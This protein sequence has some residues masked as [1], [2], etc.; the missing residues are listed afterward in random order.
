MLSDLKTEERLV[1]RGLRAEG[2]SVKEVAAL[3]GVSVSSVSLWVRDIEL[4]EE[5]RAALRARNPAHNGEIVRKANIRRARARRAGWQADGRRRAR[6]GD[7]LHHAGCML[8]WAE[9]SKSRSA[10]QFTNSDPAMISVFVDF[11]RDCYSAASADIG[12]R[13][14]LFADHLEAQR[15][16]ERFWLR[17]ARLP[18]ASLRRSVVNR[19]SS[20]SAGKRVNRLPYGTC[21]VT[22][23]RASV[24]QSIY[25]AI[26]EYGGF[27]RPEW[28]E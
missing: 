3:T 12:L 9:G 20:R 16:I 17:T 8:Y 19:Y 23:H 22:L 6:A 25:G 18:A 5:A 15:R 10:V 2:R 24:L 11:L 1:V 21:R 13:V 26:Q 27:D 28:L 4:D 7:R 14:Y